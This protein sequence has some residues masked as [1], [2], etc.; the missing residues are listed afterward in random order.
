MS[1]GEQLS[2]SGPCAEKQGQRPVTLTQQK[3]IRSIGGGGNGGQVPTL[4]QTRRVTLDK[5]DETKTR[6]SNTN[7]YE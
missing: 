4:P 1:P 3:E 6:S 5:P 2:L 7:E